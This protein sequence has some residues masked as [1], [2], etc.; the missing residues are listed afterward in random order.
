MAIIYVDVAGEILAGD[1]TPAVGSVMFQIPVALRDVVDNIVY[2]PGSLFTATLDVNGQFLLTGLPSTDSPD[3]DP[4][5][6][7]YRIHVH[8]D[9]WNVS[10]STSLPGAFAPVADFADLIP[11][12]LEPCTDD[13][14]PCASIIDSSAIASKRASARLLAVSFSS[15]ARASSIA[16]GARSCATCVR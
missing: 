13:G 10:F 12:T 8:T 1:G 7:M 6:W 9:I 2:G 5:D 14:S 3:V 4:A 15:A 16:S 11:A